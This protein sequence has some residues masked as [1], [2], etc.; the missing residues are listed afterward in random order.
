MIF[1][2]EMDLIDKI[3]RIY[4]FNKFLTRLLNLKKIRIEY[5]H[6]Q[7]IKEVKSLFRVLLTFI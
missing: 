6:Y 5:F 1:V 2:Q 7:I 3:G 4:G